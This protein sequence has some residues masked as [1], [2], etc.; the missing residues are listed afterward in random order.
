MYPRSRYNVE[1]LE[2]ATVG[3]QCAVWDLADDPDGNVQHI[4][5][6]DVSQVEAEEVLENPDGIEMSRSSG[7]MI[8]FGETSSG[9]LIAVVFEEID[10]DTV[11]PIT[12]YEV[13][14]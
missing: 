6:N 12:A 4:A 7:R 14:P 10:Q 3:Y 11:Y 8:A 5:E 9:R 13:E 2:G 1:G